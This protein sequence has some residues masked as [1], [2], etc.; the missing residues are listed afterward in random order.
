MKHSPSYRYSTVFYYLGMV[1]LLSACNNSNEGNAITNMFSK[2]YVDE[3]AFG[4]LMSAQL[5][6]LTETDSALQQVLLQDTN[7]LYNATLAY[8]LNSHQPFWFGHN[9]LSSDADS[10]LQQLE[11]L[12]Q[13]GV[14][15]SSVMMAQ[16]NHII[17]RAKQ[18][19][20]PHVDTVVNW[21]RTLT[22]AWLLAGKNLLL[23]NGSIKKLDK[24][25]VAKNDTLFNGAQLL[26][27]SLKDKKG[28]PN[29]SI[30]ES[31]IPTYKNLQNALKTWQ[32]LATDSNYL[33]QKSSLSSGQIDSNLF[34]LIHKEIP[35]IASVENDSLKGIAAYLAAYQ[36]Y[37]QLKPTGKLDSL[38]VKVLSQPP[39]AYIAT[40]RLN[41][42]RL[43]ALPQTIGDEHIWV[44][45]PLMEMKYQ[46]NEKTKFE[47]KVVI[48]KK[49][50]QTPTLWA[51][52]TNV[53]FNPPW[54][55]PP[56][57]LKN[58]VGPGVSRSGAGYLARKGLRA[59]D[60]KGRDVTASVNGSNYKQFAYRQPPG[61]HNAL[62]EVKFN[63]PNKWDIYLHDTPHRENFASR[64]R[65]LSSGCVR[66][67]Y[68][69]KLAEVILEEKQYTA[70]KIDSIV[71]TRRTKLEP[72]NRS[73]PVYIVYLTV[74]PDS[75]G[76][77]VRYLND[78]YGRD[79][80]TAS[81]D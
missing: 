15:I 32:L 4:G 69:K 14:T 63:L 76:N 35:Q 72:L 55:V 80:V 49:A 7:G 25:W 34:K 73:L 44:N 27:E 28:I 52:M 79:K 1:L 24:E 54:G 30:F 50:R 11:L 13:E 58:D 31:Q 2:A 36:Y 40:L 29:L 33:S 22:Q 39:S 8:Q 42:E 67:Q 53:V 23:G 47:G 21:D 9:G 12:E 65:A 17:R 74:A 68:P 61:A 64:N 19:E 62:G 48:G 45:I 78:V 26:A 57:I 81:I 56:T 75:T 20:H 70:S 66:V 10:F 18:D 43:R 16:V 77:A 6:Q 5:P 71:Q 37:H 51:P 60:A 38:T 41:M 46:K 3:E 59:F